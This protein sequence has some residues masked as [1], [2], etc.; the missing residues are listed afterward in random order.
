MEAGS[1]SRC[2]SHPS[3]DPC[4]LVTPVCWMV[5]SPMLEGAEWAG[6]PTPAPMGH[7]FP[8]TNSRKLFN[9]PH[10]PRSLFVPSEGPSQAAVGRGV[11]FS[12]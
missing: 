11:L 10:T 6:S 5:L 8:Q 2:F 9:T 12:L 7:H 3:S 1:L 4:F